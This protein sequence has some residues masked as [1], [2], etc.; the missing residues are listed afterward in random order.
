MVQL[1]KNL[2]GHI[3]CITSA[4]YVEGWAMNLAEL[5]RPLEVSILQNEAEIGWGIAHRYREDL[6][7]AGCGT[8]WCAFRIK[9]SGIPDQIANGSI[10]LLERS[11]AAEIHQMD[12]IR[13]S[14]EE[15]SEIT[16]IATL[17][18]HDPTMIRAIDQLAGCQQL[19]ARYIHNYGVEPFVRAAYVYILGRPADDGGLHHY[20]GWLRKSAITPLAL[21]ATLTDCDEF[22]SKSRSLAAPNSAAFPFA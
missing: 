13:Y 20:S 6:V 11:T 21:L 2:R 10:K 8:G 12:S 19:F 3:D 17:T 15:E 5:V 9:V 18:E 4:G 14:E 1:F 16:S 22:R 7:T